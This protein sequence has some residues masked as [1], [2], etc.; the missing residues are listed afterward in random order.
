MGNWSEF[1]EILLWILIIIKHM[2]V[3]GKD[4]WAKICIIEVLS[5]IKPLKYKKKSW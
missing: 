3:A 2:N 1:Q 4:C 5:S